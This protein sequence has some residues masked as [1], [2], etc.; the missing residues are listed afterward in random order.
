MTKIGI[1]GSRKGM[2][3][4]QKPVYA[5]FVE[6]YAPFELHHGDCVGTD[7][8]TH[9]YYYLYDIRNKKIVIHPPTNGT[10]RAHCHL[11]LEESPQPIKVEIRDEKDYLDRNRDIVDET[12]FLLAF[13]NK[14]TTNQYR[15]GTWYTIRYAVSLDKRVFVVYA[16][17]KVDTLNG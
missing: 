8:E 1:T 11:M 16:N 6:K 15:G 12:D 2:T 14:E 9:K 10:L 4:E 7:E 5:Q 3:K 13:P 17:G